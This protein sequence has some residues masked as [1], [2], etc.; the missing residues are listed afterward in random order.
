MDTKHL[1]LQAEN[2]ISSQLSKFGFFVSKPMYDKEGGDLQILDDVSYPTRLIRVQ[3]KGRSIEKDTNVEIP[4]KYVNENF[5]LFVYLVDENKNE[6][7]YI[8]FMKDIEAFSKDNQ[9][10]VLRFSKNTFETKYLK[11]TFSDA[12]V[13]VLKEL[14]Q[15][16]KIKDETT[17]LIDSFCLENAIKSTISIYG[18]IYPE[19]NISFPKSI[20][21]SLEIIK[22]I[23]NC[24]AKNKIENKIINCYLFITPHNFIETSF[25]KSSDLFLDKSKIRVFEMRV[26]GLISFEI[27]DFLKR[28]INS[29]NIIL[30]VS[31]VKYQPILEELR[32]EN[33]EIV[34]VCEKLD[35]GLRSFGFNWGDISYP[36]ALA[37]G[38]QRHE[39]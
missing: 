16:A 24:Y 4:I 30:T 25:Y 15:K 39:L 21:N 5:V 27:E 37:M 17:V 14:L 23:L 38:I 1:E 12:N 35:N 28:I 19:K 11:N 9:H 34:L 2:Y 6:K 20:P 18:E 10:Y 8:F 33:K 36:I 3:A 22:Q 29:E 26:E 7:L 13:E 32:G 31:D